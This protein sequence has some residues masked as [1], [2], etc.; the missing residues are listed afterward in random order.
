MTQRQTR[1]DYTILSD[2]YMPQLMAIEQ[3]LSATLGNELLALVKLTASQHNGCAYCLHMHATAAMCAG[4]STERLVLAPA[5]QDS[6]L[7]SE[8]ERA[9]VRWTRSLT[10]AP[11]AGAPD[12]DF[13]ALRRHFSE[14]EIA[15]LT[16]AI[17]MINLWNRL[18]IGLRSEHPA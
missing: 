11:Q 15:E 16:L 4:V 12:A 5:A 9:A 17:G 13:D 14:R 6:P 7:F 10:A 8:R 2:A 3:Q 18:M 1:P